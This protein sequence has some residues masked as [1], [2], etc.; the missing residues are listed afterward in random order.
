MGLSRAGPN[1]IG[2]DEPPPS[3][4]ASPP[5]P[6][7]PPSPPSPP[8]SPHAP[9]SAFG[10]PRSPTPLASRIGFLSLPGLGGSIN[11]DQT[12]DPRTLGTSGHTPKLSYPGALSIV[13]PKPRLLVLCIINRPQLSLMASCFSMSGASW[14]DKEMRAS[15][16]EGRRRAGAGS[17][18]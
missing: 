9:L 8:P 11:I 10:A 12:P 5:S 7:A 13:R 4:P 18:S 3:R 16:A 6:H 14:D 2:P 17:G 15:I 1:R